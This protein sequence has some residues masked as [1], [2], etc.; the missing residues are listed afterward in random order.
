MSETVLLT[1]VAGFIPSHVADVLIDRGFRVLGVDD[2]SQGFRANISHL[3]GH[4]RFE[5]HEG[6]VRDERLME[7]LVAR[8]DCIVHAAVR[9]LAS[10]V[11]EPMVDLDVNTRATLGLLRL[12]AKRK[13]RRF[14][15]ASSASVYGSPTKIPESESDCV[16]PMS[17][18]AVSKLAA[19]QYC[20]VHHRVYGLP[21]VC[22]R[23]F[24]TYGPRQ[25]PNSIY[26]GVVSIFID[27]A[28]AGKPLLVFGDG[29]QTRDFGYVADIARATGDAV[30]ASGVEG[31]VLNLGSGV[32]TSVT[33]LAAEIISIVS[34][35]PAVDPSSS[36]RYEARRIV[37][38]V[39][40]RCADISRAGQLLDYRPLYALREGLRATIE[41][42]R[43]LKKDA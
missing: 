26:G 18:Y 12:A 20:L 35:D 7:Q 1:G 38:N 16:G 33:A 43:G 30:T 22:L 14:V 25:T 37:D 31:V 19:E 11:E 21:V 40:R 39:A 29:A 15:Y 24:N 34:G 17:P 13:V 10:S 2:F 36:I 28:L 8:A 5:F 23:Y 32:E 27:R 3:K 4:P 42:F 6:D 9:G 41:W